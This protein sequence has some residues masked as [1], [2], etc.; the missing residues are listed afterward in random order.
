MSRRLSPNIKIRMDT[1]HPDGS[2]TVVDIYVNGKISV[3]H[4]PAKPEPL[5]LPLVQS[6]IPEPPSLPVVQS[7]DKESNIPPDG[8]P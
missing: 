7:S 2:W 6:S 5:S 1:Q 8:H 3:H 4:I